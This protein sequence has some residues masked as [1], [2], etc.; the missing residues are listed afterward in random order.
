M[1][2]PKLLSFS[3]A[4]NGMKRQENGY[5][6]ATTGMLPNFGKAAAA[7]ATTSPI[8]ISPVSTVLSSVLGGLKSSWAAAKRVLLKPEQPLTV[9][10]QPST[11]N[12]NFRRL[13]VHDEVRHVAVQPQKDGP[14]A[15]SFTDSQELGQEIKPTVWDKLPFKQTRARQQ[16]AFVANAQ[17]AQELAATHKVDRGTF[18]ATCPGKAEANPIADAFEKRIAEKKAAAPVAA[19]AKSPSQNS[20]AK[21]EPKYSAPAKLRE[22]IFGRKRN[23]A[24]AQPVQTELGLDSVRVMRNDLLDADL[25]VVSA[26]AKVGTGN[27]Q[28]AT[29]EKANTTVTSRRVAKK[30][31]SAIN[32][33]ADVPQ[34]EPTPEL[35]AR[36]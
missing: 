12:P 7:P 35:I 18:S 14:A 15:E 22:M 9:N 6:L 25:E 33:A 13:S 36:V 32:S 28:T 21:V 4:L 27:L 26:V 10:S 24:A 8:S 3:N 31:D 1:Q 30:T 11:I 17:V 34:S 19:A 23:T 16:A 2:F 5:N 29:T 20:A